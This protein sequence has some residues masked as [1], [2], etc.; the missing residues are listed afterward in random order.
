[1]YSPIPP[2]IDERK[3]T[4]LSALA[5]KRWQ[6]EV[7]GFLF[8]G[9]TVMSDRESQSKIQG[10]SIALAAEGETFGLRWKCANNEWLYLN[11]ATAQELIFA[12]LTHVQTQFNREGELSDQ[13]NAATTNEELDALTTVV[14][15]F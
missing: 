9:K 1:M 10:L 3:F 8:H 14:N 12:A 2:T 4:L 13:I 15:A 6:K 5:D 7:G 11:A